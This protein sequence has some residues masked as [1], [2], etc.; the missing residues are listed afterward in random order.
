MRDGVRQ[1]GVEQT[2]VFGLA[3]PGEAMTAAPEPGEPEAA[4]PAAAPVTAV[5][6][7]LG[8]ALGA[9]GWD[10]AAPAVRDLAA[11]A[12]RGTATALAVPHSPAAAGPLVAGLIA[13]LAADRSRRALLLCPAGEESTWAALASVA[14]GTSGVRVVTASGPVRAQRRLRDAAL[15]LLIASPDTALLLHRRA[16][17]KPEGIDTVLLAWPRQLETAGEAFVL[18]LADMKAAT[19]LLVVDDAAAAEPLVD[20]YA[21]KAARVGFPAA[22]A[23]PIPP[24]DARTVTV[25]WERRAA[26]VADVLELMDPS[27]ATI[28]TADRTLDAALA[29]VLATGDRSLHRAVGDAPGTGTII[30]VDLPSAAQL[31]TFATQGDVVLLVPPTAEAS[32]AAM[33][34][35][36]RSLRLPGV[37]EQ[38]TTQAAAERAV[39]AKA[40]ETAEPMPSLLALAPLFE[41]H[42]PALVAAV[43]HQLWTQARAASAAAAAAT[44]VPAPVADPSA[45]AKIFVGAGKKDN[46]TV[47]DL[48]AVLTKECRVEKTKIGRIELRDAF[49]LVEVPAME[50]ER[51]AQA[52]NGATIR[53]KRITARV[54]RGPSRGPR[55]EGR[56][57]GRPPRPRA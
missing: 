34:Q 32:A 23:A 11:L 18:L 43:L 51:I 49:M 30:C 14:A 17:L 42:D 48:V 35:G 36:R 38:A 10:P 16:A 56:P 41:R 40:L 22:D 13:R 39:I 21:R 44:A 28:W 3:S 47:A 31:A 15:D 2:D 7:D 54:D 55:P 1:D 53:R 26:A 9:L 19:R 6:F 25:A 29:Q 46:A 33:V 27:A 8:A 52:L 5:P 12:V 4:V 20:R 24:A 37:L 57:E 45:S 50:A